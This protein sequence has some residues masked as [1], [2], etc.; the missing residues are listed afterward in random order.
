MLKKLLLG[1]DGQ[2]TAGDGLGIV[3]AQSM[4]NKPSKAGNSRQGSVTSQNS[5]PP[6]TSES[7]FQKSL[8]VLRDP[9]NGTQALRCSQPT[10]LTPSP[11]VPR[12]PSLISTS[13][14]LPCPVVPD[15]DE[16]KMGNQSEEVRVIAWK[17][18]EI[19]EE[20]GIVDE[21]I[22]QEIRNIIHDT[23]EIHRVMRVS[24]LQ[25]MIDEQAV[26]DTLE[27][28]SRPESSAVAVSSAMASVRSSESSLATEYNGLEESGFSIS[29]ESVTA[30]GSENRN[31][32]LRQPLRAATGRFGTPK[33]LSRGKQGQADTLRP[34][35][36]MTRMEAKFQE[37]KDRMS[38]SRGLYNL[39]KGRIGRP[40]AATE[41]PNQESTSCECI[42]CFDDVPHEDAVDGL[43]C[44]HEY[45][46][47]CFTQLVNTAILNEDTFPPKCCLTEIP[48]TVMRNY[49]DPMGLASFDEKSLE[50]AVP[51]ASRYYCVAPE[52][53]RWVDTRIAKRT[54]GALEC[55]RCQATLC[56]VCRGPQHSGNQDC[57]QDFGLDATLEQAERAGWR[58]YTC[59][60]V[61]RTCQCTEADQRRREEQLQAARIQREAEAR[62]EEEEVRRAV[63]VVEEAERLL[64]E[65][66]EAE[67]AREQERLQREAEEL[68]QREFERVER[69]GE[70]FAELRAILD[71]VGLQQKEA[72]EKRHFA[73]EEANDALTENFNK[74]VAEKEKEVLAERDAKVAENDRLIKAMQRK[75]ATAIMETIQRHRREQDGLLTK[76]L[77]EDDTLQDPEMFKITMLEALLPL[78][79]LE[80][81]TLKAHQTREIEK[82]KQRGEKAISALK[83]S[84]KI[85]QMRFEEEEEMACAIDGFHK[86]QEADFKWFDLLHGD[87][88]NMLAEDER[89]LV[90][91][92][93]DVTTG[94]HGGCTSM[95]DCRRDSG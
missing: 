25:S 14:A 23:M 36:S 2:H 53:A 62:A 46:R 72:I 66:R 21:D 67:E 8:Q 11:H 90:L 28:T 77:P 78:Q 69:I 70:R 15:D 43:L 4:L 44:R 68:M 75:H 50:Y 79:E 74:V 64:R 18:L 29:Q 10:A 88:A 51:L 65:E 73:Q 87:R 5:G 35:S 19:P 13:L 84:V 58:S 24:R 38:R 6:S 45:C 27:V 54:N 33:R 59:G 55:P 48:K 22:P 60:A 56:T 85:Q 39:L 86:Q 52:C 12:S 3:M 94:Q 83:T 20:L 76:P 34:T 92:G 42:S 57:P 17:D 32:I 49:L 93:G 40:V 1:G 61:W 16:E 31:G 26:A 82:W 89:R 9:L 41:A 63:A 71:H 91:S 47:P 95:E 30:V 81:A 80:R 7:A 37:S